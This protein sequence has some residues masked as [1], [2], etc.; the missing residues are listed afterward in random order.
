VSD[1][2]VDVSA[3]YAIEVDADFG[4]DTTVDATAGAGTEHKV[5]GD[6]LPGDSTSKAS[7][8]TLVDGATSST[9]QA[10]SLRDIVLRIPRGQWASIP[11]PDIAAGAENRIAG[12]LVCVVGRVGTGKSALLAGLVEE[13]RKTR[14]RVVLGGQVSYGE[15]SFLFCEASDHLHLAGLWNFSPAAGMD[16]FRDDPTEH[17]LF[18]S[19]RL[20]G[21]GPDGPDHQC[22]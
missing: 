15:S 9:G 6:D 22:L 19:R 1:L 5:E 21:R 8:G 13:M 10:F 2:E 20:C 7:S 12:S 18:F 4:F 3:R 11:A 17:R 16:P 14:G